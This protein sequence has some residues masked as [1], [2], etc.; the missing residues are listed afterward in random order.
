[1]SGRFEEKFDECILS[2]TSRRPSYYYKENKMTIIFNNDNKHSCTHYRVD[3][4]MITKGDKCDGLLCDETANTDYFY[5]LKGTDVHHGIK[6]LRKSIEQL[7]DKNNATFACIVCK[8]VPKEVSTDKQILN[9][10]LLEYGKGTQKDKKRLWIKET[11]LELA[12]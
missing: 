7:G 12:L 9:K 3:G 8:K 11:R 4:C 6:Q 1:M 5:E 2:D 10:F